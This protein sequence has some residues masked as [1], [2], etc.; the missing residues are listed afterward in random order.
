VE[1]FFDDGF[2]P[3]YSDM[4]ANLKEVRDEVET[5]D[6]DSLIDEISGMQH[7]LEGKE[8]EK[9]QRLIFKAHADVDLTEKEMEFLQNVYVLYYSPFGLFIDEA[10][11]DE[12]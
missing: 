5:L 7:N 4:V 3:T 12:F 6:Q 2:E 10:D 9:V 1:D 8:S 11:E